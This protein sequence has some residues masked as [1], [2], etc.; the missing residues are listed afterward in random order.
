MLSVRKL[1]QLTGHNAGIYA[2]APGPEPRTFLSAAG[3]GWVVQWHLD[4][5]E[6][7]RVIAK[8]DAQVFSI[9]YL[10]STKT[11]VAGDMNGGVHWLNLEEDR[12]NRH[13]AHH[14]KGVFGILPVGDEVFTIGGGGVLTRWDLL[15][16]S[17]RESL[18]LSNQSLRSIS[19]APAVGELAIG[20]SDHAIYRLKAADFAILATQAPAHDNSVFSLIHHPTQ[21]LLIS[22]S[23]DAHLK[24]WQIG[25][26][27]Q[28]ENSQP[29]HLYTIND[30]IMDPAQRW[31]ISGSR[32]RHIKI[33]DANTFQLLKVLDTARDGGHVNS[34]NRLLWLPGTQQ[35]VSAS[36]DRTLI[37]WEMEQRV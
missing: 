16:Q 37:I 13:I 30:L 5:P 18:H 27:F 31:L 21:P 32:D 7:G 35:F 34:V 24:V 26:G 1:H 9:A 12:P 10:P 4:E 6:L 8:V 19:Y 29:A 36:D 3:D 28:L 11:V 22:G 25:T 20:S 17:S 14:Q 15:R 33:W 23:R 2:L